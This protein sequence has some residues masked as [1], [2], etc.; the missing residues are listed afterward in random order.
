[1]S[2]SNLLY[3][4]LC[5]LKRKVSVDVQKF[6][7]HGGVRDMQANEIGHAT[8]SAERL[9]SRSSESIAFNWS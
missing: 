1:M 9:T 4:L 5:F 8:I 3:L 7:A 2:D 6:D